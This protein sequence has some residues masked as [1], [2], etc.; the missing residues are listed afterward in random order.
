M[1]KLHIS[2]YYFLIKRLSKR[3][4]IRAY[5][6]V[7]AAVFLALLALW[8]SDFVP[9]NWAKILGN[10]AVDEILKILASSML[11]VA[12]FS[13]ST[14]V[15]AYSAASQGVTPRAARLLMEDRESLNALSIFLGAFIFSIISI[16]ALSTGYYEKQDRFVLFIFTVILVALIVFTIVS[17]IEKLSKLGRVHQTIYRVEKVTGEALEKLGKTLTRKCH[18]FKELPLDGSPLYHSKIGYIRSIDYAALNN[19]AKD[20]KI[21]IYIEVEAGTYMYQCRSLAQL[22]GAK[23]RGL[24]EDCLNKIQECFD[25]GST[26]FFEEDPRFG[27]ITLSEV[28]SRALSP[29]VNDPGSAI[30]VIGSMIRLFTEW[31]IYLTSGTDRKNDYET[32]DHLY[33]KKF[34]P[35]VIFEDIV[36]SISRDGAGH[37]EVVVR[38]FKALEAISNLKTDSI[39]RGSHAYAQ[40]VVERALLKLEFE[41]DRELLEKLASKFLPAK[42]SGH[43]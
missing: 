40:R 6:S 2:K 23:S 18:S 27:F 43:L 1:V 19:L 11:M 34:R 29:A 14:M 30:D 17:W 12:T 13:L 35:E 15:A 26:R 8:V 16:I 20:S 36:N 33:I 5:F 10:E 25:I 39:A 3:L 38:L 32:F 7:A 28:A 37:I 4:K 42:N 22:V 24:D 21:D 9:K 41:S 31:D